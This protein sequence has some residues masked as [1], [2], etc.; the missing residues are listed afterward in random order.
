MNF[1]ILNREQVNNYNIATI[2]RK[3]SNSLSITVDMSH[4]QNFKLG[5]KIKKEI[6]SIYL[7]YQI[8]LQCK[9][10]FD[11]L[12]LEVKSDIIVFCRYYF[13]L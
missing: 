12:D 2:P 6:K 5:P 8:I 9:K 3:N 7:Q 11:I 1:Y 4:Y 13:V 10:K